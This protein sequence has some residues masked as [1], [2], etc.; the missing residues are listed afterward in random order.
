[1]LSVLLWLPA[2]DYPFG[3]FCHCVVCSSAIDS[4]WIP[5]WYLVSIVLSVLL[6]LTAS[7][8]QFG[9][10]WPL[11]CLSF[12]DW[13]LLITHLVSC[14][15]CVV[16]PTNDSFWLPIWYLLAIM[17]SVLLWLTASDYLFG[18]FWPLCCLSFCDWQL[19]ITHLVYCGHCVVCPV[20]DSF[21]LPIWYFVSIVLSVLLWLT[22]SDY[23][24]GIFKLF[25]SC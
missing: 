14:S 13:Q 25:L 20:I 18:I 19:L 24:F 7:D 17:L 9:I 4:F 15:H 2:S 8:Y 3:V 5:I 16:C 12:C 10:L 23:P 21:W 6:W 1:M 22:A 11:C